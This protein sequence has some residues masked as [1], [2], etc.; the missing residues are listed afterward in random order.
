MIPYNPSEE[1]QTY[2]FTQVYLLPLQMAD[3]NIIRVGWF[4]GSLQVNYMSS[5]VDTQIVG[6]TAGVFINNMMVREVH[7]LKLG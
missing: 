3:E 1:S 7:Y 4:G 2:V 6:A 5:A